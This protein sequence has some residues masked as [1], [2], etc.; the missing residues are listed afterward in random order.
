MLIC[1]APL[2][3]AQRH[4]AC[5]HGAHYRVQHMPAPNS[6]SLSG[7]HKI[8]RDVGMAGWAEGVINQADVWGSRIHLSS[9]SASYRPKAA[10]RVLAAAERRSLDVLAIHARWFSLRASDICLLLLFQQA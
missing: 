4:S 10:W 1:G 3:F 8:G 2:R 9:V 6:L 5:A 7:A